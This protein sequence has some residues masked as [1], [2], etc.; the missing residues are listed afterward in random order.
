MKKKNFA[1]ILAVTILTTGLVGCG[2]KDNKE[3][4]TG[5]TSSGEPVQ[6]VDDYEINLG[7]YNC[8][9][10][11]GACIG[12]ATGIYKE[13]G[14][15]VTITG[16]GKVPQAMAAGQMDAGYIGTRGLTAA[17]A[18]GSPIVIGANNHIG[19]SMYLVVANDIEKPEDL[20]GQPVA[21]GDISK[22]EGWLAGYSKIL[23]L[24]TDP[25][26][27]QLIT[28]G[29]DAE[30][31]MAL[32]AGQIK[33]FTCCDPWGSMAEYEGTG[34][35]MATYMEMDDA[36]GVCCSYALNTNFV[37]EHPELA[38]KLLLAHQKSIEYCYTNPQKAA[39]IFAEYYKVPEE[40][41]LMTMYKKC[42]EEGRT[43]TWQIEEEAFKHGYKVYEKFNLIEK[44]P[45]FDQLIEYDIYNSAN[46][47]DFDEFIKSEVDS[48]FPIGMSYEDYKAKAIEIDK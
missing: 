2:K 9:H 24:S 18:E 30:K 34:K 33:A 7:Y 36:M 22:S 38:E 12:E 41:A 46:L 31:Y 23:N 40:V 35:I 4:N 17:N 26:K 48:V 11:V 43:L 28:M 20:Y 3:M 6:V 1:F 10:M 47:R 44:L 32:V 29:S 37:K 13:L 19:G 5:N 27:Y 39:Q 42:V 45:E 25:A 16:N 8:D 21:F 14:L 15:D